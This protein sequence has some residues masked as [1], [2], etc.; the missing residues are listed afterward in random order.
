MIYDITVGHTDASHSERKID[1]IEERLAGIERLLQQLVSTQP[2][3]TANVNTLANATRVSEIQRTHRSP[4]SATS[5]DRTP[6]ASSSSRKRETSASIKGTDGNDSRNLFEPEDA[7]TFEGNSSLTA[8]TAFASEFCMR[9]G[10]FS[11]NISQHVLL[12]FAF[13]YHLLK[14][15]SAPQAWYTLHFWLSA[16]IQE[17]QEGIS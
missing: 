5:V 11:S 15:P 4:T 16:L 12:I 6:S 14:P 13:T 7:E 10:P 17:R 2:N 3:S 8:H 9:P 1:Q